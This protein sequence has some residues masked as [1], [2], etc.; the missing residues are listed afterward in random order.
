LLMKKT[1][2]PNRKASAAV[3]VGGTA[4][5]PQSKPKPVLEAEPAPAF[6]GNLDSCGPS[7]ITGWLL[8]KAN[9]GTQ[10]EVEIRVD[11]SPVALTSANVF[12]IDLLEG[13]I[14]A[15]VCAFTLPLPEVV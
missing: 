7:T 8:D 14:G 13:D 11:G 2:A 12:R 15:G 10:F 1:P 3:P 4:V 6:Q 5:A 9:P